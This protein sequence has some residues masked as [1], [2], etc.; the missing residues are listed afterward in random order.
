MIKLK[1]VKKESFFAQIKHAYADAESFQSEQAERYGEAWDYF[2]GKAPAVV[3]KN[4]SNYVEP[5]LR[6]CIDRLLPQ[7]MGIFTANENQAVIYRPTR[8]L[9]AGNGQPLPTSLIA[10]AVN[11][12]I[13]EIYLREN[14]G[15]EVLSHAFLEALVSG[16]AFVK[17][18]VEE[19]TDEECITLDDWI[20][21]QGLSP[22]LEMFPDTD[23]STLETKTVKVETINPQTG[24]EITLPEMHVKGKLDLLKITR[25]P[26]ISH[27]N[28]NEMFVDRFATEIS[29]ARYVCH[30]QEY[31]IGQLLEMGF[32]SKLLESADAAEINAPLNKRTMMID[33]LLHSD[34][35]SIAESLDP[36][37]KRVHLFEHFIYSSIPTGKTAL[38]RV[39]A[40]DKDILEVYECPVIP[41]AH[42]R[43][44]T[45]SGSFLG[46]SM[47]DICKVYQDAITHT[48]RLQMDDN[49]K[50]VHPRFHAI[51]GEYD[52]RSLVDYRAGGIVQVSSIG[53]VQPETLYAVA[54]DFNSVLASVGGSRDRSVGTQASNQLETSSMNNVNSHTVSLLLGNQ[55]IKDKRIAGSFARTLV[56]PM[57]EGLYRM[58]REES[59]DLLLDDGSTFNTADL[60]R[61]ADFS[62]DVLTQG[63]A[64]V[65]VA[66]LSE[67]VQ[68]AV[69]AQ[70]QQLVNARAVIE[71]MLK[72]THITADQI[73]RFLPPEQPPS[74]EDLAII[75]QKKALELAALTAQ[76]EL[77]QAQAKQLLITT[78]K[79]EVRTSEMI[80]DGASNRQREEEKSLREFQALELKAKDTGGKLAKIENDAVMGRA[81]LELEAMQDRPVLIGG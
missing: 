77:A 75:E 72:A 60:P 31:P 70:Q 26:Q 69:A 55:E 54:P 2:Q 57:F 27:V 14:N 5:V 44:I 3:V 21:A 10:D 33:G 35:L 30:R 34:G 71:E 13:N 18:F 36:M 41:F 1:A 39:F 62:I 64:G 29:D 8:P 20:P 9:I 76:L 23:V 43:A 48:V 12:R 56:K 59:E 53:A 79:E 28:L 61:V 11:R 78:A 65:M 74:E 80:L 32:S 38:Y 52:P 16:G 51:K 67:A 37:E 42:G 68:V 81:E 15:Y 50:R 6:D 46:Q 45:I 49:L 66:V 40:T 63:D 7:Q 58:L 25:K 24:E 4:G 17:W 47:H 73:A 19:E 22:I